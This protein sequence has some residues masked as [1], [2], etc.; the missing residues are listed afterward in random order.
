[1]FGQRFIGITVFPIND[2]IPWYHILQSTKM[3]LVRPKCDINFVHLSHIAIAIVISLDVFVLFY[4][5]FVNWFIAFFSAIWK[6]PLLRTLIKKIT[7]WFCILG[8][9]ISFSTTINHSLTYLTPTC[10][11]EGFKQKRFYTRGT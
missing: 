2:L 3:I 8:A 5:D 4:I 9:L 10:V 1:M 7:V 6:R 11:R